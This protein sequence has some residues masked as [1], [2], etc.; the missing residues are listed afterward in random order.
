MRFY[1]RKILETN[2]LGIKLQILNKI[3]GHPL[4]LFLYY[5]YFSESKVINRHIIFRL[6]L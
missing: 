2:G 1:Q 5:Y 3:T 6:F 4:L